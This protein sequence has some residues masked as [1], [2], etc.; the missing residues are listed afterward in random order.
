MSIVET[1]N[2]SL[3][4]LARPGRRTRTRRHRRGGRVRRMLA[5]VLAN[6]SFG[7]LL[8]GCS[9][10]G[11]PGG[12]AAR[13]WKRP[14]P[15]LVV[16][17]TAQEPSP[18]IKAYREIGDHLETLT[19]AERQ[20]ALDIL[21]KGARQEASP[22]ARSA[23]IVSLAKF[24]EPAAVAAI[25]Q[26]AADKSPLVRQE[27]AKAFGQR[28]SESAVALL[29]RLA[30]GD[31]D[32]DVRTTATWALVEI[33]SPKGYPHLVDCMADKELGIVQLAHKGLQ[34]G[35]GVDLGTN[36]EHWAAYVKDGTMPDKPTQ[37]ARDESKWSLPRLWK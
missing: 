21:V 7:V 3:W 10:I 30:T 28:K 17:R 35:T 33:N 11:T 8:V 15:P 34:T 9:G 32:V 14:D 37:V 13:F 6:L 5:R 23:A 29:G 20:E 19:D 4:H 18:R 22:L 12:H 16:L 27:V 25:E 36:H 26:A 2:G 24:H 31:A 1:R